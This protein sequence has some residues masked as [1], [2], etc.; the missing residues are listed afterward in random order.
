MV[1]SPPPSDSSGKK[2]CLSPT[3]GIIN[4]QQCHLLVGNP[5][6]TDPGAEERQPT[7]RPIEQQ[8]TDMSISLRLWNAAYDNLQEGRDTAE[9]VKS[10]LKVLATVLKTGDTSG[11]STSRD[12]DLSAQVKDPI[13]RQQYLKKLVE[14]GVKKVDMS[15]KTKKAVGDITQFMLSAKRMINLAVR[16][17]LPWAGV[18][19]GLQVAVNTRTLLV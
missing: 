18:C 9:L 16:N 2:E 5:T 15:P 13:R 11:V 17:I 14:E 19:L 1:D 6:V 7:T 12:G 8:T 3:P 10:Y 4:R